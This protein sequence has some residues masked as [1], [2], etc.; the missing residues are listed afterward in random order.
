MSK[1]LN[2]NF[3]KLLNI[4]Y[5]LAYKKDGNILAQ[6]YNVSKGINEREL[7][8]Y[9]LQ[10][11]NEFYKKM[12][13]KMLGEYDKKK[14][15]RYLTIASILQKESANIK[16]MPMV[17]SVIYN[18]LARGMRLQMDGSLKYGKFAK[19]IITAKTIRQ[20]KSDYNTYKTKA[21]PKNPVC[22]VGV[23]AIK[24]SIN[25]AKSNYLYFV[26]YKKIKKHIF[27]TTYKEHERHI[28]EQY[29]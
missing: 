25:P 24:A 14:W 21:L 7:I 18:R 26:R 17:S 6:T 8:V 1:K 4:Y 28:K 29:K 16:E 12:S 20:N 2:L 22:S 15:Y 19:D 23:D 11:S 3:E 10:T 9:L 13:I 5:E 27:S